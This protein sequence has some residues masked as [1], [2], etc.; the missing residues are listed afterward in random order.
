MSKKKTRKRLEKLMTNPK[1][2]DPKDLD[3]LLRDLGFIYREGAGSHVV[4]NWPTEKQAEHP[5]PLVIPQKNPVNKFIIK[6]ILKEIPW[7]EWLDED[8]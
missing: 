6:E 5:R 2:V 7:E 3:S 8:N 1:G 4:Y